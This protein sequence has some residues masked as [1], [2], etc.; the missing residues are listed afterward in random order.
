MS[1]AFDPKDFYLYTKLNENDTKNLR[2]AKTKAEER[3]ILADVFGVDVATNKTGELLLDFHSINYE[4]CKNHN[5]S[6][7]KISTLLGM[8][9]SVLNIMLDRHMAPE[10]GFVML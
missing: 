10:E 6:N 1:E 8:L 4:F 2:K 7:E 3:K 5:Y 9:Y